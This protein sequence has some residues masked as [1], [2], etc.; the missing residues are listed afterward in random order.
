MGGVMEELGEELKQVKIAKVN[1]DE[2]AELAAAFGILSIP[3]LVLMEGGEVRKTSVGL[4]SKR[5]IVGM[6]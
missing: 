1:I 2:E 5:D 6:F 4:R 3:T